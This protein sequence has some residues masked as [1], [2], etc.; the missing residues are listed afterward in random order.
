MLKSMESVYKFENWLPRYCI[1]AYLRCK[2]SD[3]DL[4][5]EKTDTQIQYLK[6]PSPR[7]NIKFPNNDRWSA[8]LW[9]SGKMICCSNE[10]YDDALECAKIMRKDIRNASNSTVD[11]IGLG[12][13]I[14]GKAELHLTDLNSIHF[15]ATAEN[16][17]TIQALMQLEPSKID[18]NNLADAISDKVLTDL[19]EAF[20]IN[21]H[22][23][24]IEGL[25]INILKKEKIL[26]SLLSCEKTDLEENIIDL[27]ELIQD[28]KFRLNA[29]DISDTLWAIT[30]GVI[31]NAVFQYV[32]IPLIKL[33]IETHM[34]DVIIM[35]DYDIKQIEDRYPVLQF[36]SY[37]KGL[38]LNEISK[39][40]RSRTWIALLN[41]NELEYKKIVKVENSKYL[42]AGGM[43]NIPSFGET[44]FHNFE[45]KP[46]PFNKYFYLLDRLK[47]VKH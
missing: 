37:D 12:K 45:A 39:L 38:T 5:S 28:L 9:Q 24:L 17:E 15:I 35:R 10:S 29:K 44:G 1:L 25:Q 22:T 34:E 41:L 27:N 11:T 42:L 4:F 8:Q 43:K 2:P 19:I 21:I 20:K 26:V 6:N 32:I 31:G 47:V 13:I 46:M 23:N 33:L 7:L 40:A 14:D 36:L 3:I 18:L 16:F 30:L